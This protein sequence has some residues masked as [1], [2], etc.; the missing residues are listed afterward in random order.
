[1]GAHVAGLVASL[2][3]GP[4]GAGTSPGGC[5]SAGNSWGVW[6]ALRSH[7]GW[8]SALALSSVSGPTLVVHAAEMPL[9][10]FNFFL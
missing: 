1:M 10:K 5:L 2:R 7:G 9:L 3:G 6:L 8:V 4:A